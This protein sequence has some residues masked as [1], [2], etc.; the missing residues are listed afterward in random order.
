MS[1]HLP[2]PGNQRIFCRL[3]VGWMLALAALTMAGCGGEEPPT[4]DTRDL[5]TGGAASSAAS[6][7]D[8][9]PVLHVAIGA[10][11]S[12]E[13]TRDYYEELVERLGD[14][15]G[16]R[17]VFIQRRTYAEVNAL[18]ESREADVAFVCSGPYVTGHD[19]FGMELLVAPVAHGEAV[20][21]CYILAQGDSA[22]QSLDDL[23]GKRFAFTDPHSNTGCLAPMYMLAKRG[24]TAEEFFH[25]TFFSHSHDNSIRAVAKKMADGAAVDS[26]IWDFMNTLDPALT[27]QT[28][29]VEKS[30][31]YGIPPVVVHPGLPVELKAQLREAFLTI[32]DDEQA[33]PLLKQLQIDRFTEIDDKA[34]DS[35]REMQRWVAEHEEADAQ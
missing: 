21:Y 12:P 17:T 28:R 8:K 32:H 13:T 15:I 3:A 29:I 25:E 14:K 9:R 4:I 19:A 5:V 35:V 27:G 34:Y 20:Y 2:A 6:G 31:P 7:Q 11:I 16:R 22:E 1:G 23:R 26:L 24:E 10:M 18:V 30:P 33:A